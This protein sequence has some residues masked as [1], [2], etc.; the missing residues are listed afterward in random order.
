MLLSSPST[1]LRRDFSLLR[2]Q[3]LERVQSQKYAQTTLA[4]LPV[5]LNITVAPEIAADVRQL[6]DQRTGPC[7]GLFNSSLV[8]LRANPH[9]SAYGVSGVAPG[10]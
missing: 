6:I 1:P 9:A 10:V 2:E 3:R 8:L 5:D 4:N 7:F